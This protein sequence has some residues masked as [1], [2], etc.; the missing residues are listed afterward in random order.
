MLLS[1]F[2]QRL[3]YGG[4]FLF[5]VILPSVA[6]ADMVRECLAELSRELKEVG[7]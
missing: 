6:I 7:K 2:S 1:S 3:K 5:T 4:R